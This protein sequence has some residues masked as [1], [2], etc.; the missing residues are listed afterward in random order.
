MK[1]SFYFPLILFVAFSCKKD[2]PATPSTPSAYSN[3]VF[4]VNQGNYDAGNATLTFYNKT[5]HA[6]TNDVFSLVNNNRPLGDVF[7]SMSLI[8]GSY[9]LVVNNSGKIEV[10]DST[11][12]KNTIEVIG[13][14]SPRYMLPLS[15]TKAYVSDLWAGAITIFDL[16]QNKI[17]GHISINRW[18]EQMLVA[19]NQVFTT[20]VF[21]NKV[22][23]ID[24]TQDKVIDSIS[25]PGYE[26][27][28]IVLDKNNKIWVLCN[29]E[30]TISHTPTLHKIDPM[31]H[32]VL[33]TFTFQVGANAARPS[34]LTINTTG[35]TLYFLCGGIMKMSINQTS[36][37]S[38]AFIPQSGRLLFGLGI[39]PSNGNIYASDAIDYQQPGEIYRYTS[40]GTQMD[41][42][43]AGVCPG[44]FCFGK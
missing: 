6:A 12:M 16:S 22:D 7:Q 37:P 2:N 28:W 11:T 1:I 24:Y 35:D 26:P 30:D 42:F 34:C 10:C 36:L 20:Q 15:S 25:L 21:V 31:T 8:N 17:T 13:F 4:V 29:D 33:N 43:K 19:N 23:V 44:G 32:T 40:F 38:S 5:S 41:V 39:D 18:T 27:Q 14:T 3:G 9:Y